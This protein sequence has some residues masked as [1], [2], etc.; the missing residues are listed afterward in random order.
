MGF[1]II[2]ASGDLTSP[3]PVILY[4]PVYEAGQ[5]SK[6]PVSWTEETIFPSNFRLIHDVKLVKGGNGGLDMI[7]VAGREGIVNLWLNKTSRKW[8]HCVIGTGLPRDVGT[9]NP[10]WGSGGVDFA[11]VNDD[12]VGYINT[13]EGFHGNIVSVYFKKAGAPKGPASLTSAAYWERRVIDDYGPL[14]SAHVGTVH[15]VTTIDNGQPIQSFGAACMGA[16]VGNPYNQGVYMYTPV[17]ITNGTFRKTTITKDS[18][19]R[20]AVSTFN[21]PSHKDVASITY[22]VPNYHTG[23]DPPTVRINTL[24]SARGGRGFMPITATKLDEKEVLVRL[25]RPSSVPSNTTARLTMMS[26]AGKKLSIVVIPPHCAVKFQYRDALKVIYGSV[27]MTY[28]STEVV[29]GIAPPAHAADTTAILSQDGQVT[30]GDTGAVVLLVETLHDQFQGPFR[31]M[32]DVSI[33]NNFPDNKHVDPAVREMEFPFLKVDT[34][35]W[36]SSGLWNDFEFYNMT[37]IYFFFHDNSTHDICHMQAWTLGIGE[38]ARFHNHSDRSFCEI[39][40]CL[41]NGGGAGG[42]RYFPNDYPQTPE[43]EKHIQ[44][45]ELYKTFVEANSTLLVVPSM[46]EHGP[47][48]KIKPGTQAT[49]Q[50]RPNNNVDY[51]WHAWLASGFGSLPLPIVPPLPKDE[52]AYD[53]WLAFEFPETAFQY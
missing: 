4:T 8:D 46:Y 15:N 3:A 29:R 7:L 16:P 53:V 1:P 52:Q 6:G 27:K 48:W 51:P 10:Y 45:N 26:F 32:S 50:I 41:S 31:I 36:A 2:P 20:L 11:A 9:G 19:A 21:H 23:P 25:P 38:T 18:A 33:A 43:A 22:Y 14:S 12:P 28:H 13:C 44:E 42:M 17:D 24:A 5:E 34:L 40:Y 47:L 37:G 39:H 30:G 35:D 49:P